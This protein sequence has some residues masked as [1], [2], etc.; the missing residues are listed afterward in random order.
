[1]T[2]FGKTGDMDVVNAIKAGDKIKSV[3]IE[4]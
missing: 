3:K 2:V 1:H 4:D